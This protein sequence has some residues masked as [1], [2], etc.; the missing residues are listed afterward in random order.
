M[1]SYCI[2]FSI[3]RVT[4]IIIKYNILEILHRIVDMYT[5]T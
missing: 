1:S 3:I 2:G 4:A 5:Y